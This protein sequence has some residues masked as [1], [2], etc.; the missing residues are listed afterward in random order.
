LTCHRWIELNRTKRGSP[1][2]RPV[3]I[4]AQTTHLQALQQAQ[5]VVAGWPVPHDRLVSLS[6]R[7]NDDIPNTDCSRSRLRRLGTL[8]GR[9]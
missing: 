8:A 7:R 4:F 6:E 2:T 5:A 9:L 3:C 1:L